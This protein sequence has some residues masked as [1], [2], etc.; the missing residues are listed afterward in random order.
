MFIYLRVQGSQKVF[1]RKHVKHRSPIFDI[2]GLYSGR[3]G[4]ILTSHKGSGFGDPKSHWD[5]NDL[6]QGLWVCA[7][8]KWPL[9]ISRARAV[10]TPLPFS[11]PRRIHSLITSSL[12]SISGEPDLVKDAGPLYLFL[13]FNSCTHLLELC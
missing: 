7:S 9:K 13:R 4:I 1:F 11:S 3:V 8:Q 5:N 12:M 10:T 2:L 6:L